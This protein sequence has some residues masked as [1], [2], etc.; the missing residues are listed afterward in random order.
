[1][2]GGETWIAAMLR[3]LSKAVGMTSSSHTS[4]HTLSSTLRPTLRRTLCRLRFV[5]HFVGSSSSA[6]WAWPRFPFNEKSPHKPSKGP[7]FSPVPDRPLSRSPLKT[8]SE[9]E[10]HRL[11][12]PCASSAAL[13]SNRMFFRVRI[14][15][16]FPFLSY[17]PSP[18]SLFS[19]FQFSAFQLF[20]SVKAIRKCPHV[21]LHRHGVAHQ[22]CVDLR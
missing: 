17:S 1:M 5:A 10:N 6:A 4:S 2:T 15:S 18:S 20:S 22:D 3:Q 16:A 14:E 21:P 13:A 8:K 7:V 19:A 11:H 9:S 12:Y